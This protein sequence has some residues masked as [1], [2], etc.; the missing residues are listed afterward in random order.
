MEVKK[1]DSIKLDKS[2]LSEERFENKEKLAEMSNNEMLNAVLQQLKEDERFK[3]DPQ[4]K[5]F[6]YARI[7]T[8][9]ILDYFIREI[10]GDDAIKVLTGYAPQIY[11]FTWRH[12]FTW[13]LSWVWEIV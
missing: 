5:E 2:W 9:D 4:Y 8:V 7:V 6:E 1:S 13:K 10:N 11:D 3:N 12:N